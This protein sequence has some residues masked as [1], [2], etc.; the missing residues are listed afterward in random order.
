[1]TTILTMLSIISN[2]TKDQRVEFELKNVINEAKNFING[3]SNY[4][5]LTMDINHHQVNTH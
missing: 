1:M 5:T 4:C 2:E 3:H